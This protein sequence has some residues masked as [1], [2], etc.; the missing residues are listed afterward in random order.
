MILHELLNNSL[1]IAKQPR[2]KSQDSA[3]Q[4]IKLTNQTD[5]KIVFMLGK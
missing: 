5:A 4:V 3:K 1:L 2:Q